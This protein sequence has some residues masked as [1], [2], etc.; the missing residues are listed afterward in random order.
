MDT[1]CKK[2]RE[3]GMRCTNLAVKCNYGSAMTSARRIVLVMLLGM[4][5]AACSS[6][7]CTFE[8]LK[9]KLEMSMIRMRS[10]DPIFGLAGG[11]V[12]KDTPI[13]AL[14]QRTAPSDLP[15][16]DWRNTADRDLAARLVAEMVP[17]VVR[18]STAVDR[19]KSLW[20][21]EY[22]DVEYHHHKVKIREYDQVLKFDTPFTRVPLRAAHE[23]INQR[24]STKRLYMVAS[25]H[26]KK[27]LKIAAGVFDDKHLVR[28][29]DGYEPHPKCRPVL[30]FGYSDL[31][32]EPHY[33]S[34]PNFIV[35][36]QND[37][38][39]MLLHPLQEQ[40]LPWERGTQ[41]VHH[42]SV[43]TSPRSNPSAFNGAHGVAHLLRVGELI[44]IPP[45][46]W[47]YIELASAGH[48]R[49][50]I[51]AK[52]TCT[53]WSTLNMMYC[54]KGYRSDNNVTNKPTFPRRKGFQSSI[55]PCGGNL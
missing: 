43:T 34:A 5:P 41:H 54:Y 21:Q 29:L 13:P 14:L 53:F 31:Q 9:D 26:T 33:D 48:N 44:H 10:G 3:N 38:L 19:A 17:F 46:W 40:N 39:F 1:Y 4:M 8:Q 16:L 23:Y 18:H 25:L 42:S 30:R 12:L 35:Q 2:L 51:Q 55:Y 20:T 32:V 45:L 37:K 11:P 36:L 6:T 52:G 49:S 47:H 24:N 22:I 15:I 28:S 50:H 27:A 7:L